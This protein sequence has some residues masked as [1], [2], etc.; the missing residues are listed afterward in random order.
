[1]FDFFSLAEKN[2]KKPKDKRK[3]NF[4]KIKF[5][6]GNNLLKIKS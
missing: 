4:L 3:P 1:M 5:D 2:E 6:F